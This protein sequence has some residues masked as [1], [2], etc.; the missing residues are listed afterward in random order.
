MPPQSPDW[1]ERYAARN[2]PW[3]TCA[4]S[5]ELQAILAE[6]KIAPCDTLELGCGTGTNAIWLARQAFRVTAVDVAPLAIDEAKAKSA[7]TGAQVEWHVADLSSGDHPALHRAYDFVFDRGVYHCMRRDA[8]DA[9]RATLVRVTKPG[10]I[11][12]SLAG[13]ANDP[14]ASEPG[15]PRVTATEMC[16]ELESLFE[17]VQLREFRFDPVELGGNAFRPWAWSAL[18]RRRG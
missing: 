7:R 11:W 4:P 6:R 1:N 8:L 9:F 15:P 18:W 2:I 14:A 10:T 3:D 5:T 16:Q 13:N 12:L 17:L